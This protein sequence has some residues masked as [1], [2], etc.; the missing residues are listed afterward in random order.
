MSNGNGSER[1]DRIEAIVESNSRAIQAIAEQQA[2]IQ[3]Q[4]RETIA[5]D[6]GNSS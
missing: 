5:I 4:H 1:L 3:T 2:N 6:D